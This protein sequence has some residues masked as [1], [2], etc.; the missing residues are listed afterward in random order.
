MP[1]RRDFRWNHSGYLLALHNAGLSHHACFLRVAEAVEL[2]QG[3][4]QTY[5]T[6]QNGDGPWTKAEVRAIAKVL[7]C[8]LGDLIR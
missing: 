5:R 6:W 1:H 8:R 4:R 2:T 3:M 7:G